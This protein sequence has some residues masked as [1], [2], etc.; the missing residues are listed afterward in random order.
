MVWKHDAHVGLLGLEFLTEQ[1]R[2]YSEEVMSVRMTE[3]VHGLQAHARVLGAHALG[4][5]RSWKRKYGF[6]RC[7]RHVVCSKQG[8]RTGLGLCFFL[9]IDD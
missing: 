1:V 5:T 8:L 6:A 4:S 9:A 7:V 2:E 3:D